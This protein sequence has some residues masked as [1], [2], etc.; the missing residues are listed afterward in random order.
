V[1]GIGVLLTPTGYKYSRPVSDSFATLKGHEKFSERRNTMSEV[2]VKARVK[3]LIPTAKFANIEIDLEIEG[4][5][6]MFSETGDAD[7]ALSKAYDIADSVLDEK[8]K[9]VIRQL[10]EGQ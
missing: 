6:E 9:K 2:R 7:Q 8:R 3:E 5:S 10:E 4:Q 1:Q